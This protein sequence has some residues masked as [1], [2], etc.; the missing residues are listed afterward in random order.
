M[1]QPMTGSE[2]VFSKIGDYYDQLVDRYGHDYRACDYGRPESQIL[3]FVILSQVRAFD[4]KSVL[5]V[6]CGFADFSRF[7]AERYRNVRY[8]GIDLSPKMVAAARRLHP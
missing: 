5:D 8:T 3:K 1:R 2:D 7:L 4:N 6:G